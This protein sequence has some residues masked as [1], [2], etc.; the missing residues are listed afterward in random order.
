MAKKT[1][2]LIPFCQTL[3]WQKGTFSF[4]AN[5]LKLL[6]TFILLSKYSLPILQKNKE[7]IQGKCTRGY[8]FCPQ[9]KKIYNSEPKRKLSKQFLNASPCM[10]W[11]LHVVKRFRRANRI[12]NKR[13]NSTVR[14]QIEEVTKTLPSEQ[15]MTCKPINTINFDDQQCVP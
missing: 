11:N 8:N 3:I 12:K 5:L 10:D 14:D 13:E 1:F 2:I 9:V 4:V 15:K 6:I 7:N